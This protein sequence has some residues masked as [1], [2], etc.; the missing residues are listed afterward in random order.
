MLHPAK[1]FGV[2]VLSVVG[3]VVVLLVIGAIY[4]PDLHDKAEEIR[5]RNA[6]TAAPPRPYPNSKPAPKEPSILDAFTR[7][8]R[9][10]AWA[11][12][13]QRASDNLAAD[14]VEK[15][16]IARRQGDTVQTCAMAQLV[17]TAYL[18]AKNEAKYNEWK[19][20]EAADCKR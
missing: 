5:R 17:A 15:Y 18:Q 11:Y 2:T 8:G 1:I 20:I 7:D 4:G 9:E 14:W 10:R 3:L 16:Q 12:E 6:A 19:S 13:V